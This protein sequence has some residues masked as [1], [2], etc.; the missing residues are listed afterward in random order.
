M[1]FRRWYPIEDWLWLIVKTHWPLA[2]DLLFWS[3][4]INQRCEVSSQ[5]PVNWCSI[6][7]CLFHTKVIKWLSYYSPTSCLTYFLDCNRLCIR[8]LNDLYTWERRPCLFISV[9][10]LV[11]NP[12]NFLILRLKF[13]I[14]SFCHESLTTFLSCGFQR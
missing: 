10:K 14:F 3:Q 12:A 1:N 9:R 13:Y 6:A 2:I 11:F 7:D 5:A 4:Q 8:I